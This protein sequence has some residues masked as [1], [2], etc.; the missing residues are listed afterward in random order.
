M[1]SPALA[2]EKPQALSNIL[3]DAGD[4]LKAGKLNQAKGKYLLALSEDSLNQHALKNIGY[5]LSLQKDYKNSLTYLL[6]AEKLGHADADIYNLLGI[7]QGVVGDT[8]GSLTS[9][10]KAVNLA[11]DNVSYVKNYGAALVT[12]GRFSDAIPVLD[13]ASALDPADGELK[14]LLGNSYAG[15][16]KPKE[17]IKNFRSAMDLG[18]DTGDLRYHLGMVS[19][20][21]GDFWSA[22]EHYGFGISKDPKNLELRQRLAVLYLRTGVYDQA[23]RLLKDNL[24]RD[25]KYINSRVAL[26]ACY[27]SM[28]FPDSAKIE[29]QNVRRVDKKKYEVMKNLVS[30]ATKQYNDSKNNSA[31]GRNEKRKADSASV[32]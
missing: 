11:S 7:A 9:Y 4:L 28:G 18:F 16:S 10:S 1:Q 15:L 25:P 14:F 31:K 17:S 29:L 32:R 23:R 30:G 27:A 6:K 22:E 21:I 19:E 3:R 5:I 20:A 12:A 2:Q 24:S 8:V 13:S 26:G